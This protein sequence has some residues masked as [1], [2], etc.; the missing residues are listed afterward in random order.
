MVKLLLGPFFFFFSVEGK[1]VIRR[2]RLRELIMHEIQKGCSAD[3]A[4]DEKFRG[5]KER[6]KN[7]GLSMKV[8]VCAS[9]LFSR[10]AW[11]GNYYFR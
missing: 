11:L 2:G 5:V 10:N 1:R 9:L 4:R 8:V 3:A 6:E 7:E